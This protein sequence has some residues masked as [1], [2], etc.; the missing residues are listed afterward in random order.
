[1]NSSPIKR[2]SFRAGGLL[3]FGALKKKSEGKKS[4]EGVSESFEAAEI[5]ESDDEFLD[6]MLE[7]NVKESSRPTVMV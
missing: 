5:Q 3:G 7:E 4:M 1:M 2:P 6:F